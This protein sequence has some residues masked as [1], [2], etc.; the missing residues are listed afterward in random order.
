MKHLASGLIV[1][2][3]STSALG[4]ATPPPAATGGYDGYEQPECVKALDNYVN[5]LNEA[6]LTPEALVQLSRLLP[7]PSD[8]IQWLTTRLQQFTDP[9][10]EQQ[11]ERLI[12]LTEERIVFWRGLAD[13]GTIGQIP[14]STVG[15]WDSKRDEIRAG[16]RPPP[17]VDLLKPED[18]R[19]RL[20]ED[21]S[22][23]EG[24]TP[25]EAFVLFS[26]GVPEAALGLSQLE[27]AADW[28]QPRVALTE[29]AGGDAGRL[30]GI[31]ELTETEQRL[32]QAHQAYQESGDTI[33]GVE[34]TFRIAIALLG[35]AMGVDGRDRGALDDDEPSYWAEVAEN[36]EGRNLWRWASLA[37]MLQAA[38]M[39]A[40]T[41]E[42]IQQA[43]Q[44]L[45]YVRGVDNAA[46]PH[47]GNWLNRLATRSFEGEHLL[48]L[49][50]DFRSRAREARSRHERAFLD[51]GNLDEA[52]RQMQLA[53]AADA[54][55]DTA[56]TPT[57]SIDTV[58]GW[59][60]Y[61]GRPDRLELYLELLEVSPSD[62]VGA[63]DAGYYGIAIGAENLILTGKDAKFVVERLGRADNAADAVRQALQRVGFAAE[64]KGKIIVAPDRGTRSE[65]SLGACNALLHQ[66]V[67]DGQGWFTYLPSAM[68]LSEQSPWTLE[69]ALRYWY[70]S[71]VSY[72]DR[73][74]VFQERVSRTQRR[75]RSWRS[76][77][78]PHSS[79]MYVVHFGPIDPADL[80]SHYGADGLAFV[81]QLASNPAQ[82]DTTLPFVLSRE[83]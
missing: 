51:A 13:D 26:R 33:A 74:G 10:Q 54:G 72:D 59:F 14:P 23:F 29:L 76:S 20:N 49:S 48:P 31:W 53:K 34:V 7:K 57:A 12:E 3:V 66:H 56:Q 11:A 19:A 58:K 6:A 75:V 36:L 71:G 21:P 52:F 68:A 24:L 2:V 4:Q 35:R 78:V 22:E 37:R 1:L 25:D 77:F 82:A 69:S 60:G 9:S 61:Q 17:L 44:Q 46:W 32:R 63:E 41:E 38:T 40:P 45:G 83:D 70:Q 16:F 55:F 5:S 27:P 65:E 18:L 28:D 81:R 15:Q 8:Q 39:P 62:L 79:K 67:S 43:R 47:V 73:M 42:A 64:D 30:P 80:V 50:H